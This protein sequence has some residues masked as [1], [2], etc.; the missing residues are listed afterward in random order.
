MTFDGAIRDSEVIDFLSAR[1]EGVKGI[2][3]AKLGDGATEGFAKTANER[4]SSSGLR[5]EIVQSNSPVEK[6]PT[7]SKIYAKQS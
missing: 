4:S 2:S 1:K 7:E 3:G 5:Q 6:R